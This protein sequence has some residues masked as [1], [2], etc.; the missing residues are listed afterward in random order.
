MPDWR[1]PDLRFLCSDV[2]L[3]PLFMSQYGCSL[4]LKSEEVSAM[5]EEY[6]SRVL[7]PRTIKPIPYRSRER[8]Q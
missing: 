1:H 2:P 4:E 5:V 6:L 3:D 8:T 7:S